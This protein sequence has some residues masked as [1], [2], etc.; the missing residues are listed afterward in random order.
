MRRPRTSPR[1]AAPTTS[2]TPCVD[3]GG[4]A[5]VVP[6]DRG[7]QQRG[8]HDR[9]GAGTGLVERRGERD[10]AVAR[11]RAVRRLDPD[12]ARDGRRLADRPARVRADG[13][14]G[15]ERGEGCRRAAAGAARDALE[16]PRVARGAVRGVLGGRAHGELVHVGLA[17]DDDVGGAQ[18]LDHGR[19][20]RRPPALEDAG[21]AGGGHALHRQDVLQRQRHAGQRAEGLPRRPLAVDRARGLDRVL[22]ERRAGTHGRA[23]RPRRSGRDGPW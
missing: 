22:V 16:V 20:V 6:G 18:P 10:E 9:A 11:D 7:V 4:V 3:R 8:V 2:G 17:E 23:R 13:E 1:R 21:A 14:R 5:G 12:G 19:V 15:L